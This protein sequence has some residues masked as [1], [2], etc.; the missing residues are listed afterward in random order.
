MRRILIVA[1]QLLGGPE[2]RERLALKKST[3]PE[4]EVFV[5]VPARST[6]A[7]SDA[8]GS[9]SAERI[10]KLEL[11]VLR[12]LQYDADGAVGESDPVAAVRTLLE[13]RTFDEIIVATEPAS[14]ASRF[15]RMDLAH[16]LERVTKLPVEEVEGEEPDAAET[17]RLAELKFPGVPATSAAGTPVRVLLVEDDEDDAELARL[18]LRRCP[19]PNVL[20]TVG[21]GAQAVEWLRTAGGPEGVDLVLVDLKMPVMD[22]F[23]LL[24]RLRAEHDLEKLAVVVLTTSARLEDRERAHDLGAHAYVTKEASFPQY[25]DLLEGLLSDVARS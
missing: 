7:P 8:G 13:S 15:L 17:A 1:D 18:A 21:D 9:E 24:E 16:R 5:L 22:G 14:G 19:T 11:A 6:D 25:R 12:D 3:D 10:L 4:I 2:L 23:E 20:E